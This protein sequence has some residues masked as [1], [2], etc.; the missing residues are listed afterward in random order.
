VQPRP[1]NAW[2]PSQRSWKPEGVRAHKNTSTTRCK[3]FEAECTL[4]SFLS[5]CHLPLSRVTHALHNICSIR[6]KMEKDARAQ[7]KWNT[8]KLEGKLWT[9]MAREAVHTLSTCCKAGLNDETAWPSVASP[10]GQ[11]EANLLNQS[12][13]APR[14]TCHRQIHD[15][16]K[17]MSVTEQA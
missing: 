13:H 17:A 5:P 11:G 8:R 6:A 3:K 15:M 4:C 7:T 10:R 16:T 14:S 12:A 2:V 1:C 9:C